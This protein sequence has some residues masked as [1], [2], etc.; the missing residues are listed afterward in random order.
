M[1]TLTGN[2]AISKRVIVPFL[3]AVSETSIALQ[4]PNLA[5]HTFHRAILSVHITPWISF[6]F[7]K[8]AL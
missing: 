8:G 5:N 3:L 1:K 7:T 4:H 2:C 6:S